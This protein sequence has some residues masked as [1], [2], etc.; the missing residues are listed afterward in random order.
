[1]LASLGAYYQ[2]RPE[3]PTLP[4][5]AVSIL[6]VTRGRPEAL[7][8]CLASIGKQEGAPGFELL[9]ASHADSSVAEVVHEY[10]PDAAVIG[11]NGV[12]PGGAR[13][14]L[15]EQATGDL[16]LFLDDDITANPDLLARVASAA[17]QH[18]E[19][20]VFGGP[21]LTPQG[22]TSFQVTQGAV[23]ASLVASGPVRHR[24]G[25][26]PAGSANERYFTL[27][28]LAVRRHVMLPFDPSLLCAEENAV[29]N[30][31]HRRGV[32]MRYDPNMVVFHERR[33]DVA[34]FCRQM[35]KYG[36]G[37]GQVMR[38]EPLRG[39]LARVPPLLL[40]AYLVAVT[41]LALA[42]GWPAL[43]PAVAYLLAV[44]AEALKVGLTLRSPA[45]VPRAAALVVA[46]HLCYGAG[47][48][49]GL[50]RRRPEPRPLT[51]LQRQ[52]PVESRPEPL[53]AEGA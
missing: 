4:T 25:A 24:Y 47:V 26:H 40:L 7:R 34:G 27:C 2:R 53:A 29:L 19:A 21:N 6:I 17:A 15:V 31:L 22:S 32:E 35:H 44:V 20:G 43:L 14:L 5:P 28:N 30:E 52:A 38:Q 13:N 23:L 11:V 48:L 50:L 18:P 42:V 8:A 49:Q 10:F 37:R 1:M 36:R 39:S 46:V 12:Y 45:A 33:D 41:P 16:L 3:K 51:P 9:V